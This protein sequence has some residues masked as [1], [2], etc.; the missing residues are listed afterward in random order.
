MRSSSKDI[1][2]FFIL[3]L[4]SL[5]GCTGINYNILTGKENIAFI[6]EEKEVR[7]GK[8]IAKQVE[9]EY[10]LIQ[11]P[12]VRDVVKEV[13]YRLVEN[14]DRKGIVYHFE[15]IKRIRDYDK[16][17]PNAFALPGGYI[18]INDKILNLIGEDNKDEIAAVLAHEISHIVLRHSVLR[19]QESMGLQALL[20]IIGTNAK[21]ASTVGKSNL[22]LILMM[23]AYTKE[24]ERE[25]DRLAIKYMKNSGYN[26]RAIISLFE[27]IKEYQFSSSIKPYHVK[28]H[29]YMDERIELVER[30]LRTDKAL[31]D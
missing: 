7:L 2:V 29:P 19:L 11:N 28:T 27:K 20:I 17:E 9:K 26:P 30:E 13:G 18:Y 5:S 8:R 23:L 15:A 10:E 21:D 31:K 6:S 4:F 25:A 24:R 22:A 3:F 16:E 1:T 12:R 14:C